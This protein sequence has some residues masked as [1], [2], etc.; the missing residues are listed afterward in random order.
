[1]KVNR[2]DITASSLIGV[3]QGTREPRAMI[4][5]LHVLRTN[6]FLASNHML[7]LGQLDLKLCN[8]SQAEE[9]GWLGENSSLGLK[10]HSLLM[11]SWENI[12][13]HD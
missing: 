6:S 4:A 2:A 8:R 3:K 10:L 12:S 9:C 7:K 13:V 1:M 5:T 11:G